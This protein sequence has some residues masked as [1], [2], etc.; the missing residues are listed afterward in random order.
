MATH[1]LEAGAGRLAGDGFAGVTG[2]VEGVHRAVADRV[3][4]KLG[5]LGLPSR[6]AHR[7]ITRGVYAA[8]RAGGR[9]GAA[10]A[11]QAAAAAVGAA[12]PS[13]RT[14][15]D[16]PGGVVTLGAVN[17]A[18]GDRL[19]RDRSPL[20]WRTAIRAAGR[21]VPVHPA[22]LA[23]A[24][25][26][27]G[28]YPIVFLHG[29]CESEL[30]WRLD[31]AKHWGDPRSTHGSRL[32][33]EFGY[34]PVYLRYNTG[35]HVSDNG[36]DLHHLVTALVAGWPVPVQGLTLV[37]HSM[38]GL[39]IRSAA[40]LALDMGADWPDRLRRVVYLGAPH[41]GA[42][43]EVAAA[44][45]GCVLRTLPETR[46]FA[47][48]LASR[49]VGIKDL[50]HGTVAA[51]EWAGLDLDAWRPEPETIIELLRTAEH[52]Y[53]GATVSRHPEHVAGRILGDMLVPFPSA[54]GAGRRRR[55]EFAV[56][57]GHHVGRLHHF[58]LLNH[59]L[60]YRRMR[61]WLADPARAPRVAGVSPPPTG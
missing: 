5:P 60:V 25:P 1:G 43:L 3:Y 12:G 38:G 56:D 32:A 10:A 6:L 15:V 4:R 61:E 28:P 16:R 21:E 18:W 27:A 57:A 8:V 37:G 48:A 55:L 26:G 30:A 41:L 52:Y 59:P 31:G 51:A 47:A 14:W 9:L 17:G 7:G 42:P 35:R 36:T 33:A 58:D 22:A 2:I 53:I 39:V 13:S 50:R 29:L 11:G 20:A 19:D 34:T 44:A 24:F 46:P 54:S 45:T 40:A 49:S 23:E